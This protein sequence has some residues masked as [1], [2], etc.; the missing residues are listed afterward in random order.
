VLTVASD[1][2]EALKILE[3]TN[4]DRFDL[5]ITDIALPHIRGTE[6]AE[7]ALSRYTGMKVLFM[8]GYAGDSLPANAAHFIPKPF[9][10]EALVRKIRETLDS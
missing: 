10:L 6:L 1:G 7:R 8:S 4:A 5:M 3:E 9:R 2:Q